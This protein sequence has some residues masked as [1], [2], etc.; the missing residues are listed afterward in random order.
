MRVKLWDH[1]L[2]AY[3]RL[4]DNFRAT[5]L[6][7][8]NLELL[9]VVVTDVATAP[10]SAAYKLSE[11]QTE[12][13]HLT[14]I[15]NSKQWTWIHGFAY[16][17]NIYAISLT[18]LPGVIAAMTESRVDHIKFILTRELYLSKDAKETASI[19]QFLH[20]I[21]LRPFSLRLCRLVPVDIRLP[22]GLLSLCSTY[23]IALA[24]LPH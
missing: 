13:F 11:K 21:A 17:E 1:Y 6:L 5:E 23:L 4:I 15:R 7:I 22:V 16:L 8:E 14:L 18:S 3:W 20:V 24:Q 9:T 2:N 10:S 12:C 19:R